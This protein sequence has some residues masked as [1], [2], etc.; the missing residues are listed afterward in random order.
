MRRSLLMAVVVLLAAAGP[1]T[2]Q[3]A[4]V[5]ASSAGLDRLIGLPITGVRISSLGTDVHDAQIESLLALKT[6]EALSVSAVRQTLVHLMGLGTYLDVRVRGEADGAG[7]RIE[8]ELIRLRKVGRLVFKGET[9][10]SD[11]I[12]REAVLQRFG[13]QPP[14]GR[15]TDVARTLEEV[16][17][18]YGYLRASVQPRPL[19][20]AGDNAGDLVLD[21]SP[22]PRAV[23]GAVEVRGAPD[24]A[25]RAIGERLGLGR[26]DPYEPV[27]L[28]KRLA[29]DV[30]AFRVG[31]Y[32][33]ARI[34][35]FPR[36]NDAADRVDL[37][38]V[39]TRG[40]LVRVA[41]SGDPLPERERGTLVPVAREAS[42]DEDLL[43]DSQFRI[44]RY[45]RAQGYRDARA[46]FTRDESGD[47][48]TIV[49]TV[50][51][52]ALYRV[53]GVTLRS[54][55][56]NVG[57]ELQAA[58]RVKTGEP[59]VLARLES[60]VTAVVDALRRRGFT[61][62]TVTPVTSPG[63]P[64]PSGDVPVGVIYDVDEGPRTVVTA[65]AFE[66]ARV[67]A[68]EQL[69][70]FLTTRLGMPYFRSSVD[71]DREQVLA[72]Y[73]NRGYRSAVVDVV[74][75]LSAA[76][77]EARLT[78]VIH[79]GPQVLVEHI[80]VVGNTRTSE[81]TIRRELALRPG[82]A[83]GDAAVAES[84]RRLAALGLFRR[85]TISELAHS[86]ENLRDIVV[87]VEEAPATTL[88]YGGGLEFQKVETRE[89]APRGF[90][91]IGRRNL[92]GKNR[93]VNLFSRVSLRRRDAYTAD[94]V[95][96]TDGTDTETHLEY[97]IIGSYREPRFFDTRG[98]LQ[99]ASVFEQGS[100]TS[101]R[102]RH[103][104]AR[105]DFVERRSGWSY[106]GQFA[107][108]RNEIFDDRINPVDRP[109]ID[110]LFPQLRLSSLA[111]TVAHDT[112]N[113][114]LEPVKGVLVS[115]NGEV[116]L[117]L[118]A[119]QV[120]YFKTY[121]Q[122]FAYRQ[123]PWQP[124]LVLAGGLRVGLGTGFPRDIEFTQLDGTPAVERVRDIPVSKRFFAGGDTTVRGF[125]TDRLG[126]AGT[127]DRDGIPKGGH[128]ELIVNT[129]A[130]IN[131]WKDFGVVGFLDIG[132]VFPR[133]DAVSLTD[134]RAGGGIG[135]RYKS[136]I[137]PLRVD[138][139]FKLGTLRDFG[140]GRESRHAWHIGIGQAF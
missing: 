40:P 107:V 81:D 34:D 135:I 71:A 129:E 35:P 52:G 29:A 3:P 37:D 101:F 31:G 48:L 68:D 114:P 42:A 100:R 8:I 83:L 125:D 132:N 84:Q 78:F 72:E 89:F 28:R 63:T 122:A 98:D 133:V 123:S 75:D 88:G 93:S 51:R 58:V 77:D 15:A 39:V 20:D 10:L 38:I 70:G 22:G 115:A 91:E 59:Y 116:A 139:G 33:E 138:L 43:E 64:L 21:V 67:L 109:L 85:S 87:T 11:R 136:P 99:V 65:I 79:E 74:A 121:V 76:G 69:S 16:Y 137:G 41:F 73:R 118:L 4:G 56:G 9:A 44:E 95:A 110:R 117:P 113:D 27:E 94:T 36:V 80:L 134:L 5:P 50:T 102:Y 26:G 13:P 23:V 90:F 17:R 19:D 18:D 62:A 49:F 108:E 47:V 119:S 112:R 12:L 111:A 53:S 140:A 97:R 14:P 32:L 104:S 54:R 130:R 24:D 120:G 60:D 6:G 46:P 61:R 127:F 25:V 126:S 96:G 1:V 103:R 131:L 128:A 92:W 86:A 45:L 2:A 105:V 55:S 124:K 106:I 7:V 82:D 57:A 66:G 30:D